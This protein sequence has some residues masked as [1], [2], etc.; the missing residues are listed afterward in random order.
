MAEFSDRARNIQDATESM[1]EAVRAQVGPLL[2]ELDDA[3]LKFEEQAN[4]IASLQETVRMQQAEIER[5]STDLQDKIDRRDDEITALRSRLGEKDKNFSILSRAV[6]DMM[7]SAKR[8]AA[9]GAH[10]FNII[11]RDA[12]GDRIVT[13]LRGHP[14]RPVQPR[15]EPTIDGQRVDGDPYAPRQRAA[16]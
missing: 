4:L 7:T 2:A 13:Q 14:Q 5:I 10:A 8:L 12:V 15:N 11:N 16:R 6:G 9:V 3:D 1:M